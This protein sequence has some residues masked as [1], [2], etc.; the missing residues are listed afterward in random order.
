MRKCVPNIVGIHCIAHHEALATLDA[1]KRLLELLFVEKLEN[2]VYSWVHNST[3]RN[4]E[5]ISLKEL[6][7]GVRWLSRGQFIERIL[8]LM[9]PILKLWKT[10]KKYPL[11][12]KEMIFSVQFFLHMHE[13]IM[14]ELNKWNKNFQEEY[15]DVT[16]LGETIYVTINNLKR[17]FLRNDKF[18]DGACTSIFGHKI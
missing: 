9:P 1:S 13:N 11:Y 18:A 17:C 3:K 14:C 12:D 7:H 8:V 5:L 4:S 16:Y 6:M 10:E 15:V 2:K